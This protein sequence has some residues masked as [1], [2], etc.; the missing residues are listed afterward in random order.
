MN[1]GTQD[2]STVDLTPLFYPK[3]IAVIGVN[4]NR[5][6]GIKFVFANQEFVEEGGNVYPI[7][8]KYEELFGFR[9]YPSLFHEDIPNIDLAYIAVPAEAVPDVVRDC[10]KKRVRFGVIFTSGFGESGNY[11]L[12]AELEQ[13]VEEVK[14]H[15]RI[16]GPNCLGINNPYSKIHFY[17]GMPT[18][19][20]NISYVSMSGGNTSRL[21]AWIIS[22]GGGF[23]NIVSIGN[24][25]DLSP[26]DFINHFRN[27]KKTK[28]IAL[29]LESIIDGRKFIEEVRKTTPH[30]PIILLK[31]GQ[32]QV[33]MQA[34]RSH[35]GGLAGSAE[36][37]EALSKQFGIIY[38]DHFELFQDAVTAFSIDYVLPKNE[39]VCVLVA[40]GGISVEISDICIKNGL[41]IPALSEDTKK[42]LSKIFPSINI[43]FQNPVD[44]G[45]YGYIPEYFAQALE[46]VAKDPAIETVLFVREAER[47]KIFTETFGRDDMEQKTIESISNVLQKVRKPMICSTSP[48]LQ[49][50]RAYKA[51]YQFKINMLKQNLPVIDYIPNA[52]KIIK[53][54]VCYQ[55]Y[56]NKVSK[57]NII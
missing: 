8:P 5:V 4:K 57:D 36:I 23:H 34:V 21:A 35:T 50:E 10:G 39:N 9:V 22:Q 38:T 18:A 6:G 13:A 52:C 26:T 11:N 49:Y 43:S 42:S 37:W 20:G 16:I 29:Y 45:E 2:S 41:K 3:N 27:D 51:R 48:N 55:R 33:G 7:N 56:L 53:Q 28:T 31:V 1:S 47:F 54:M 17:P 14:L 44:L 32:S 40:G 19:K 15:T 46:I 24:S 25:V 30:K 12:Q